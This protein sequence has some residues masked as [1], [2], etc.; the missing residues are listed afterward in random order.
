M[1]SQERNRHPE[2]VV[3]RDR[4][5]QVQIRCLGLVQRSGQFRL[6]DHLDD[7]SKVGRHL[8]CARD[9]RFLLLPSRLRGRVPLLGII[10]VVVFSFP[11]ERLRAVCGGIPALFDPLSQVGPGELIL[12]QRPV[13]FLERLHAAL[14]GLASAVSPR[15]K[16]PLHAAVRTCIFPSTSHLVPA[17][18]WPTLA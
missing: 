12:E 18:H 10:V 1:K 3:E 6:A 17:S 2:N 5:Q 15:E 13:F 16:A 9:G 11:S 4:P 7:L 8:V 14:G